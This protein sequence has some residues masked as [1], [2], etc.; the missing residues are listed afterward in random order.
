MTSGAIA[1]DASGEALAYISSLTG[2]KVRVFL[3][4]VAE[5]VSNYRSL[6]SLTQQVEH[7]YHGRFLIELLQNAHDAFEAPTFERQNRVEVRFD[8]SD[9]VYGSLIVANDGLPF[10]QSNFE[11]LS[12][13]GQS[14]KDP[15]KSIGNKGIGFRSVLEVSDCPEV[16]SRVAASSEVF[17]GYCFAFRP[18]VVASLNAPIEQLARTGT[19]PIWSMT[20]QPLVESWSAEMLQKFRRQVGRR[21]V[22]WLTGETA[23]LSPYLLPVPLVGER[24]ALVQELESRDFSTVIRLPLKSPE[25][26]SYVRERMDELEASTLLFL[27][28]VASLRVRDGDS[29]DQTFRRSAAPLAVDPDGKRVVIEAGTDATAIYATWSTDLHVPTASTDFRRAVAALPGRWPEIEEV[30]V[31]MAVRLG[32]TPDVGKFSIYLPTRR[33]TGSAVHLNA[34]FFGDMSRTSIDFEDAYNKQ[35]LETAADLVLEVVRKRLAGKGE[36]EARAIVDCLAPVGPSQLGDSW[37]E[38]IDAAA[39]RAAAS[40]SEEALA[41]AEGGWKAWNMTSLLPAL[42]KASVLTEEALRAHATFDIFHRCLDGRRQQVERWA[43]SQFPE[44][45]ASPLP[46][47]LAQTVASVAAELR[48]R[49]GDWNAFW[50]EVAQLMPG[51]QSELAKHEVLLGADGELHRATDGVRVFFVPR[52]GTQDD[53]DVSGESGTTEVP[54]SLQSSVAFLSEQIQV[55]ET[56]RPTAQT[57]VRAYLAGSSLVTPFRV[58]TIFSEVLSAATPPLPQP[59]DSEHHERCSDILAWALRLMANVVARGRGVDATLRL[60]RN[61][62]VPCRG[63]WFP[64]RDASFGPGWPEKAGDHL[65]AYLEGL[66]SAASTDARNRLLQPPES[67]AWRGAGLNSVGLLAAGGVFNGLRLFE[68]KPNSWKSDFYASSSDFHLPTKPPASITKEQWLE[69]VETAQSD[70]KPAFVTSQPYQFGSLWTFPGMAEFLGLSEGAREALS[71]LVLESLPRWVAG[72]ERLAISKQGGQPNRLEVTS[73]LLHFLRT[74][75]WLAVREQKGLVWSVPSERWLVPADT[76]ANRARHFTHLRALPATLARSIGQRPQL[77]ESL[78]TLGMKFFDPHST[79]PSLALLESLTSAVG[80]K[81]VADANVL[82]GQI[83]DAWQ[84]FRPGAERRALRQIAVRGRDRRLIAQTPTASAPVFIPDSGAYVAA[85]EAFDFPVAAIGTADARDLRDWFVAVYGDR[86]QFTSA[87]ALVPKVNGS[88]WTGAHARS[89]ADSELSWLVRPLLVL[90]AHGRG[91][92]SPAFKSRLETL[93]ATKVDWVPNLQVAVVGGSEELATSDVRA[94][95][96]P[97]HKALIV[98]DSCRT[99]LEELSTALAQV[100]DREDLELSLRFVLR[101]VPSIDEAPDD[102]ATFLAPLRSLTEEQIHEVLEHL[103]GDVGH[104]ARMLAVFVR[105]I[106][107]AADPSAVEGATSEDELAAAIAT[108]DLAQLDA[109]AVLQMARDSQVNRPGN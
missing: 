82:L 55:Y 106:N 10:S 60:L 94:M 89:I 68:T 69:W 17:D 3:T 11:R 100:L 74:R 79:S 73:P 102:I 38:L 39:S 32:A 91:V 59:L 109:S 21:G 30:S 5:G 86:V 105:V 7:Q 61:I 16:Y 67:T 62:P 50:R 76:L 58:E 27:E 6:H 48:E 29:R 63:G 84:R 88:P 49:S 96:E 41:L 53:S 45:G 15:Q 80:S 34:P 75:A 22:D 26:Q 47:S 54:P 72:L 28:K 97:Q 103:K 33:P 56:N 83:R 37:I 93:G 66:K 18:S 95:W 1:K 81:D 104:A 19:V 46:E 2:A 24:S 20:G 78:R 23:Y 64:M 92:H 77:V 25:L 107:N 43:R 71:F 35:L 65:Q 12:Q 51:G 108:Q 42:P 44:V 13:L 4:E 8:A 36:D 14:D 98:A 70:A 40:L 31:S 101:A 87:L 99:H 52:Q 9:S 57:P 85:L 90:A